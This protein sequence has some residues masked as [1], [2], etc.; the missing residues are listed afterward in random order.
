MSDMGVRAALSDDVWVTWRWLMSY[1]VSYERRPE[2][3]TQAGCRKW[4]LMT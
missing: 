3:R 4:A 2:N 1:L